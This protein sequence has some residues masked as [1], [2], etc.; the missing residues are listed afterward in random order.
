MI[1]ET[2]EFYMK[3]E[4]NNNGLIT[5]RSSFEKDFKKTAY[6]AQEVAESLGIFDSK[7]AVADIQKIGN[8]YINSKID[9]EYEEA[10]YTVK[11]EID[12]L[13]DNE[14]EEM[15]WI[16][17]LPTYEE[18]KEWV[19]EQLP[20]QNYLDDFV[21]ATFDEVY[22]HL[23]HE[24]FNYKDKEKIKRALIELYQENPI[25]CW[26]HSMI[27]DPLIVDIDGLLDEEEY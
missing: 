7:Q 3:I 27:T 14:L 17:C 22:T 19:S 26:K 12:E 2:D 11:Y 21:N 4:F 25:E 13:D 5:P 10:K 9:S 15:D 16:Y 24:P 6:S 20:Y 18:F 8:E 23:S 1:N